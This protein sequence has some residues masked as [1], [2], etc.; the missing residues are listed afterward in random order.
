MTQTTRNPGP[1]F[2]QEANNRVVVID[3]NNWTSDQIIWSP[4]SL[5]GGRISSL[6]LSA[7]ISQSK[8]IR[9]KYFYGVTS[10]LAN[11]F[12]IVLPSGARFGYENNPVLN[13]F[14]GEFLP[15]INPNDPFWI[16]PSGDYLEV[17]VLDTYLNEDLTSIFVMGADY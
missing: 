1:R 4:L 5:E 16:L 8:T 12:D 14:D 11:L 7:R 9:L 6:F 15:F 17:E 3:P 2:V 10:V 13:L